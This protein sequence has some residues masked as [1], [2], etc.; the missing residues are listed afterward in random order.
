MAQN[1]FR[2][3]GLRLLPDWVY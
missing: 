2:F 1:E 3:T